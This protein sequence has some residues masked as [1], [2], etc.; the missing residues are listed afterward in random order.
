MADIQV[1]LPTFI[2]LP[3]ILLLDKEKR[4]RNKSLLLHYLIEYSFELT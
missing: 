2:H 1:N 3:K 4:R